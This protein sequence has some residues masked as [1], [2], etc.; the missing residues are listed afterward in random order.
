M[1]T[2]AR[3]RTSDQSR[4]YAP[5]FIFTPPPAV[6]GIAHANSK[7]PSPAARARWRQTAFVAPPPARSVVAVDLDRRELALEPERRARP[8]PRRRRGSSS[9]GRRRRRRAPRRARTAA[10]PRS[11][12]SEPRSRERRAGPPV[13]IVVSRESGTPCSM[14]HSGS[15]SAI[16]R[17]TR[18][19]SPTPNVTTTS[20]G[21]TQASAS[22]RRVVERRRPAA[23]DAARDAVEHELAADA[24]V[25]R[26]APADDLGHDRGVG[27]PER[28]AELAVEVARPLV[29]VRVVDGDEAAARRAR[30]RS[31]ASPRS[32]SGCGRSRR[33]RATPPRSPTSSKRRSTPAN[34]ASARSASARATPGELERGERGG[35]VQPVVLARHGELEADRLE[36]PAADDVRRGGS[37]LV[38]ERAQLGL[39]A[40]TSRGGRARRSS[41]R[42][43]SGRRS[44]IERSDS[45]PSTTSQ[46]APVP[47]FP[48][49]CGTTPPTIH[50][51]SW[52]SSRRTNAIIAAVVVFPCAPPTTIDAPERDELGE[53]LGAR[54]ALRRGPRARSRRRPRTRRGGAGSPPMSTSTP[55]SVSRKIVSRT[56]QPRTSAPQPR[57]TFAYAESPAPPIPTK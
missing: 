23:A 48:P 9:R 19:G 10:P 56:S 44:A 13:P 30:A 24:R 2:S 4:P 35:G 16:A 25:R 14:R 43:I 34:A 41:R 22:A 7:P 28:L 37:P 51:G 6:P 3:T 5:A 20:P 12:A 33:R 39:R 26:V 18:H 21:R 36:L 15:P 40:R 52:P 17:A 8:R 47:A 50:A 1:T 32:R 46:P 29:H 38:E 45:S 31:A 49:S 42:A 55:S 54:A 27:E 11:S 53:E 57:A